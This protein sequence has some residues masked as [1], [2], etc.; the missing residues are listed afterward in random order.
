MK[1]KFLYTVLFAI[2]LA[3]CSEQELIEQPSTPVG[4]T[5]VQLPTD[6]TSG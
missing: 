4:G 3:S 6:V 1:K 2:T 5:E